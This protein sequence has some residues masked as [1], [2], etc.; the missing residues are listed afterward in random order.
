MENGP[1]R[2]HPRFFKT[3]EI[4][5]TF[6]AA[7]AVLAV[8]AVL[9]RDREHP[10]SGSANKRFGTFSFRPLIHT[11]PP[12]CENRRRFPSDVTLGANADR[13]P[14]Y[15]GRL[16]SRRNQ[17]YLFVALA[18]EAEAVRLM[19]EMVSV[20]YVLRRRL[21]QRSSTTSPG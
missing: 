9:L 5:V 10:V 8:S 11:L 18:I 16:V 17:E 7:I 13:I 3:F 19:W 6:P 14:K 1:A 21:S 15:A 2:T 12:P 20:E 4:A